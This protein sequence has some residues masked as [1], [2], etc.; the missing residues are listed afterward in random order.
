LTRNRK[1]AESRGRL[2]ELIAKWWLRAKGY[3]I[4]DERA[5]TAAGEIDLIA[6]KNG[7]LA[8]IEVKSRSTHTLALESLGRRQRDRIV[9]AASIWRARHGAFHKHQP[10]YDLIVVVGRNW[11]VHYRSAWI[12]E[13]RH[14][15]NLL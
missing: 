13:G 11:P 1:N 12:P 15:E 2:A 6:L 8:F 10:R 7:H 9:R 3:R 5:R 4:L 14:A